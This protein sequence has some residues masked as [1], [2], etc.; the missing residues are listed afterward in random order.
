MEKTAERSSERGA[1]EILPC[2]VKD[3]VAST[4]LNWSDIGFCACAIGPGSHTGV[5]VA[6]AVGQGLAL[7]TSL[8]LIGITR[9]EQAAFH[10]AVDRSQPFDVAVPA[11]RGMLALQ[12][13]EFPCNHPMCR[14]LSQ[15]SVIDGDQLADHLGNPQLLLDRRLH[16]QVI[17]PEFI[18]VVDTSVHARY[19]AFAAKAKL[20]ATNHH[21]REDN[22]LT[23]GLAPLYLQP[24]D[25]KPGAGRPLIQMNK[26]SLEKTDNN[27]QG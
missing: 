20:A 8:E 6:I 1:V 14:P 7:S 12:S 24:P 2:L 4:G 18:S 27:N 9:F 19:V 3:L 10:E 25:A 13:F 5:R 11:A 21:F 26:S 17:V 16:D 22:N 23:G 15:A